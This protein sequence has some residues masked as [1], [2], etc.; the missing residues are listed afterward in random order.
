MV[1]QSPSQTWK[2]VVH[3]GLVLTVSSELALLG[4]V[5]TRALC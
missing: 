5:P 1:E 2:L 4:T 3:C